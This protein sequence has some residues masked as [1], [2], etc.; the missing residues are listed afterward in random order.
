[1]CRSDERARPEVGSVHA[2]QQLGQASVGCSK[3]RSD[4]VRRSHTL[5]RPSLRV[6]T[7][8]KQ[9]L[10]LASEVA[11]LPFTRSLPSSRCTV[12]TRGSSGF[13][14]AVSA[15]KPRSDLDGASAA[16]ATSA[17]KSWSCRCLLTASP[18]PPTEDCSCCFLRQG[19]VYPPARRFSRVSVRNSQHRVQVLLSGK[20]FSPCWMS[21][22]SAVHRGLF[23]RGRAS[24][25]GCGYGPSVSPTPRPVS[26]G[27]HRTAFS[28]A[29]SVG[30]SE[31]SASARFR[32]SSLGAIRW[33]TAARM[34]S[35]ESLVDAA[36]RS[37]GSCSW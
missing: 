23:A 5:Q 25:A 7:R 28:I 33:S 10:L 2:S 32:R 19:P 17:R 11:L 20:A 15:T 9:R 12:T 34:G 16:S 1:M 24:I 35:T 31:R 8:A 13:T 6:E 26:N 18:R 22:Y 21:V 14:I 27:S 37:R 36:R 29:R 30:S 3:Q 4:S